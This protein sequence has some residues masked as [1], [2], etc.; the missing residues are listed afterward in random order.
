MPVHDLTSVRRLY[1]G[2]T[3]ILRRYRGTQLLWSKPLVSADLIFRYLAVGGGGA[4][5]SGGYAASGGGAGGDV[6]RDIVNL[7]AATLISV[8]GSPVVIPGVT[9]FGE[10]GDTYVFDANG[11][12]E[13]STGVLNISVG[14]SRPSVDYFSTQLAGNPTTISGL[15]SLTAHGGQSGGGGFSSEDGASGPG[16]GGGGGNGGAGGTSSSGGYAG[17]G[18]T[19]DNG[20]GGG[21]AG[22]AGGDGYYS[23]EDGFV[24]GLGGIGVTDDITGVAITYGEG[25]CGAARWGDSRTSVA[26]S[27]GYGGT[28]AARA[29]G[30]GVDGTGSGGG[31]SS[32]DDTLGG[33]GGRGR[34]AV[35]IRS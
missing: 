28:D 13:F 30:N 5:R 8:T 32:S 24:G 2:P 6:L 7:G 33:T 20:G 14:A 34:F 27:G 1:R 11:S 23:E 29:G 15:L 22:G 35:H 17:G 31:G 12:I 25:G 26:G 3:E 10:V 18:S 9:Y 4:G 19:T 16:N 21:G